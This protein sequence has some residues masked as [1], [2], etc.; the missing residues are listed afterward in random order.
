MTIL[1]RLRKSA[2]GRFADGERAYAKGRFARAAMLWKDAAACGHAEA[3]AHLGE[4]FAEGKGVLQSLTDA[5]YWFRLAAEQGVL[6]AQVRLAELCV[7]GSSAPVINTTSGALSLLCP[8]GITMERDDAM[9][10]RW[11]QTA[12]EQGDPSGQALLGYLLASGRGGATDHKE[13]ARWYRLAAEQGNARA[14]LGF[15]TLLAGRFLGVPDYKDAR[16]WFTRAAEQGNGTAM[17]YL[18]VLH[19]RGLDV[20]IDR[21]LAVQYFQRAAEAGS[22]DGNRC[23]GLAYLSGEGVPRDPVAAE[24]CLRRA[25][26]TGDVE[27]MV[28]LGDYFANEMANAVDAMEWYRMAAGRGHQGAR[29]MLDR[30]SARTE[31]PVDQ[32][33]TPAVWCS[34]HG[35]SPQRS[36]G[37]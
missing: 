30:I 5:K 18:G 16:N 27:A 15:G 19:Q 3:A 24:A 28:R 14:Q 31:G 4:M 36:T 22:S 34:D 13:A 8:N 12:A 9:A 10:R 26:R 7:A 1:R 21:D 2:D 29:T 25:A 17:Y 33:G 37:S 11:A 6:R 32:R 23:L 20:P 35:G